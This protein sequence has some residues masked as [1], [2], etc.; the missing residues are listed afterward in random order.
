MKKELKILNEMDNVD[1]KQKKI[2]VDPF[3]VTGFVD[4]EGCFCV[5]FNLRQC[6]TLGIEVRP[7]FSIS[8][9]RDK[10]GVNLKCLQDLLNFFDCGFIRFSKRDNT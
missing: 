8:Q 9:T 6:L 7:S 3:W 2:L 4:G 5:N 1:L 10:T